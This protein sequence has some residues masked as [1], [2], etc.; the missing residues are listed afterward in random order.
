MQQLIA[1]FRTNLPKKVVE[2]ISKKTDQ[3]LDSGIIDVTIFNEVK[4]NMPSLDKDRVN[5]D[6]K[7]ELLTLQDVPTG[8]SMKVSGEHLQCA[9]FWVPINGDTN[10]LY[11]LCDRDFGYFM[12]IDGKYLRYKVVSKENIVEDE[13]GRNKVKDIAKSGFEH[14]EN[15]VNEFRSH[16]ENYYHTSLIDFIKVQIQQE[17]KKRDDKR[18]NEEMLK[19]AVSKMNPFKG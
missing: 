4:L 1:H 19:H 8:M 15:K 16:M 7:V 18:R 5:F 3:E 12:K 9:Y 6:I 10:L 13:I 2:K 17:R 11:Q 14:I